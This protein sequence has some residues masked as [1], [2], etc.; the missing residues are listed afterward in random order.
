MI[1]L[2]ELATLLAALS[3]WKDEITQSGN[4]SAMPY[5]HTVGMSG[6]QPLTTDEIGQ[7]SIKL[8][9]LPISE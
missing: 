7:L 5:L 9:S 8:R 3:Y 6:I 4:V 2:R 1:T